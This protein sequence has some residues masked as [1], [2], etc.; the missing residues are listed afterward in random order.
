MGFT[1]RF[2]A[3][4]GLEVLQAIEGVVIID[5][6]PPGQINGVGN[7]TVAII[8]EFADLT[9][10]TTVA[11]DGTVTGSAQPTE[12]FG[13]QDFLDKFGGFDATIGDFTKAG[14]NGF[15]AHK[16]L[17]SRLV[18]VAAN[19]ASSKG[20]RLFRDLPT[21]KGATDPS[22]ILP[23]S[24]AVV[25]AGT[26]FKT[27]GGNRIRVGKK[28][29]FTGDADSLRAHDG[30]KTVGVSA[31]T[32]AFSS[33]SLD[34]VAAGVQ[35]GDILVLGV[36][37][38]VT[39]GVEADTYRI[40][41]VGGA[42]ALTV[43]NM[44]GTSFAWTAGTAFPFRIHPGKSADSYGGGMAAA[45]A[46]GYLLPA[47][48]LDATV[49][50]GT[51]CAPT[52]AASAPSATN[53]DPLANLHLRAHVSS[54]VVYTAGIQAPNTQSAADVDPL[55]SAMLT[56][57]LANSA[58]S[59]EVN[60]VFSA[61]HDATINGLLKGHV[62]AASAVGIGRIC[63]LSPSLDNVSLSTI[64]GTS[65]P[66]VGANRSDSVIYTWPGLQM[67]VPEAA[68]SS[69][70]GADGALYTDGN[71]DVH[72]DA[73][74]SSVLSLLAPERNPGQFTDPIPRVMAAATGFQRGAPATLDITAYQAM[75]AAGIC[76]PVF[77][78]DYGMVFESG[79]NTSLT[80]GINTIARRR[81]ANFIQDSLA[82]GLKGFGKQ[83]LTDNLRDAEL[84]ECTDFCDTLLQP[85]NPPASRISGYSVDDKSGNSKTFTAA[86]V[87]VIIVNVQT[88]P[89]QDT[90]VIST[91]IGPTV[92]IQQLA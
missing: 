74:L 90:I 39:Y 42:H 81:M 43:E 62:L 51:V 10:A 25:P 50:M 37:N 63:V 32:Q 91:N 12:C 3:M 29:V 52:V 16:H 71:T 57:L 92:V 48:P 36:I 60:I 9:L 18:C 82:V 73:F 83:P 41:A 89:T 33:A 15:I 28:V 27:V 88:T 80:P 79:V 44:D 47:R 72:T 54:D 2:N 40:A 17:W 67:Y 53:W 4:V 56:A 70:K 49:T 66:G 76:A 19:L 86:G 26:E 30:V 5:G 1:R 24:A 75:K 23:M 64:L 85:N 20:V 38:D 35:K 77:D 68:G 7:G 65:D 14:G 21:C 78:S 6:N 45:D 87:N 46:G 22:P 55:Y 34:F 8:G 69:V 61:R 59:R 84:L 13:D 11:A 58:P 31:A